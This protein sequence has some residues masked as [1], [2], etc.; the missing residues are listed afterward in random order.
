MTDLL[1]PEEARLIQ[2]DVWRQYDPRVGRLCRDYL[3]LC[4]EVKELK[5]TIECYESERP[6]PY[7]QG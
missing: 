4:E 6:D 7:D 2:A 3:T 5:L 1:T